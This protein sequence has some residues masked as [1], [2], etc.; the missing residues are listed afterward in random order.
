[1]GRSRFRT[2]ALLAVAVPVGLA[3]ALAVDVLRLGGTDAWLAAHGRTPAYERHGRLVQVGDRRLY[4]DCRGSGS[5]T[6][7]LENG[8]GSGADGWGFVLPRIA[9]R[10]RICAYDRAGIGQSE[11]APRRTVADAVEE[12][13][14]LLTTAG[15][16]PPYI[17]VGMSL[18]GT[19]VRVLAGRHADETAGVVLVDA[20]LPDADYASRLG[21]D[22]AM[23]QDWAR[24]IDDTSRTIEAVERLDWAASVSQLQAS[25]VAGLPLEVLTVD[26]RL[27]FVDTRLSPVDVERLIDAQERW[28][29]ALSPG[30]TRLTIAERSGHVIQLD[31]PDLVIQAIE[32]LVALSRT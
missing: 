30:M 1:V 2:V 28:I 26:Q 31:R 5:P 13:R 8:L 22:G 18:G 11:P 12:L 14:A 9:E 15:E 24:G 7:V 6:V 23:L 29:E 21:L 20:Y 19:H 27:R 17:L 16:R 10:T 4:L 32:R 3:I 25:S